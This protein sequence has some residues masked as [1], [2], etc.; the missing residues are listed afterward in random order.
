MSPGPGR[1]PPPGS[2]HGQQAMTWGSRPQHR[3][4]PRLEVARKASRTCGSRFT[5]ASG[6]QHAA[7]TAGTQQDL[8]EG[9]RPG[10]AR[11]GSGHQAES[12][13]A[14]DSWEP[15]VGP[16]TGEGR[17]WAGGSGSRCSGAQGPRRGCARES[18]GHSWSSCAKCPCRSPRPHPL[19]HR[20][21]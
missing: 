18:W 13:S 3:L 17:S 12:L 1:W 19:S 21:L 8:A 5:Q 11:G 2:P 7:T 20:P 15:G 16:A 4:S 14:L 10:G 6:S 9:G